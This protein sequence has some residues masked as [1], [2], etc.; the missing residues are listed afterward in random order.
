M[1][2]ERVLAQALFKYD[3]VSTAATIFEKGSYFVS[4]DLKS[5]YHLIEIDPDYHKYSGFRGKT[6]RI[7]A[8]YMCLHVL[9]LVFVLPYTFS[10]KY[11][12][13]ALAVA[14]LQNSYV[15]RQKCWICKIY[16]LKQSSGFGSSH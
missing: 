2:A 3:N 13:R 4:F 16:A 10:T 7:K 8:F 5:T 12:E 11:A 14:S 6:K 9:R 15:S 1:E